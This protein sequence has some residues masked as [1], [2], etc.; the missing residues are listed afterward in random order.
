MGDQNLGLRHRQRLPNSQAEGVGSRNL[1]V[2]MDKGVVVFLED[3]KFLQIVG[4][5]H[6]KQREQHGR[7]QQGKAQ[8]NR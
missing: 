6:A 4:K 7:D 5:A 1:A 8:A 3:V 2:F